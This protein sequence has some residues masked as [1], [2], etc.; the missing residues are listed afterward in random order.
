MKVTPYFS[1]SL[2]E[3]YT[4]HIRICKEW[5]RA[6][7]PS[8]NAHKSKLEKLESQRFIQKLQREEESNKS[9]AQHEDLM[10]T[11]ATDISNVCKK[12][13]QIRGEQGKSNN[14]YLQR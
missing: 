10:N 6:G 13:K 8:S 4:N 12:L 7:R 3:A 9:K 11:Y 14:R 1:K 2:R 5:Q